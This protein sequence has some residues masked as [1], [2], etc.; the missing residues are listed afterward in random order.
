MRLEQP[1]FLSMAHVSHS[2][3]NLCYSKELFKI[4]FYFTAAGVV[5]CGGRKTFPCIS[6]IVQI[7]FYFG[8]LRSEDMFWT[9]RNF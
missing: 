9:I 8:P 5:P 2:E 6:S 3:C 4:L 1:K 7:I